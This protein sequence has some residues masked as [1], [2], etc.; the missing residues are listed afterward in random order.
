MIMNPLLTGSVLAAQILTS[1]GADAPVAREDFR[2]ADN[3]HSIH[4]AQ[5]EL[6]QAPTL[7]DIEAALRDSLD[8]NFAIIY[9]DV[10]GREWRSQTVISPNGVEENATATIQ[11]IAPY[12]VT[13]DT[14]LSID[15][16]PNGPLETFNT[17]Y[18]LAELAIVSEPFT[19]N[20]LRQEV[21]EARS[22]ELQAEYTPERI[23]EV[24]AGLRA[25]GA[26]EMS[27]EEEAAFRRELQK[28]I[29]PE[30]IAGQLT[31]EEIL[32]WKINEEVAPMIS[33]VA[34]RV[35]D[36]PHSAIQAVIFRH[37]G[38]SNGIATPSLPEDDATEG[39]S[40]SVALET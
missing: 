26:I 25:A 32:A 21:A 9:D 39:V 11:Q 14:P 7:A 33:E 10:N 3:G 15:V 38:L 5:M 8:L 30:V 18:G 2:A 35:H 29:S 36:E 24:L 16:E 13:N 4:L 22:V 27:P 40:R 6:E 17:R 34:Q 20:G 12:G 1:P 28:N 37:L 31:A 19:I 23:D